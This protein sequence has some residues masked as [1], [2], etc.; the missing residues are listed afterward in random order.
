VTS[1]LEV[2]VCVI[3]NSQL[4]TCFLGKTEV[5]RRMAVLNDAPFIKVEATKFT[6]VRENR[7]DQH[8]AQL[9]RIT[10]S[11]MHADPLLYY[12]P[13]VTMLG[14]ISRPGCR[15]NYSRLDG[16]FHATDAQVV[17]E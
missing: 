1:S 14:G 6:E 8:A 10:V 2:S 7:M 4:N 5:A 3:M 17:D 11:Q 13:H 15:S 12:S 16:H 9:T